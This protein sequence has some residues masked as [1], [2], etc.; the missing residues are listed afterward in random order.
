MKISQL[1][2]AN[3]TS[4]TK[5][6]VNKSSRIPHLSKVFFKKFGKM[7]LL[8]SFLPTKSHPNPINKMFA[9]RSRNTLSRGSFTL[10]ALASLFFLSACTCAG[11]ASGVGGNG[12]ET[13]A[14]SSLTLEISGANYAV[15]FD[16]KQSAE[17]SASMSTS[18]PP[19]AAVIRNLILTDGSTAK[20][21]SDNLIT[22]G[23]SVPMPLSGDKRKVE[24][25]VIGKDGSSRTYTIN[26]NFTNSE[27]NIDSL[28]LVIGGTDYPVVAFDADDNAKV[29]FGVSTDDTIPTELTI[30][31]L[32]LS[33]NASATDQSGNSIADGST[34]SIATSGND[35]SISIT[36][37][38]EDGS[39]RT[40]T[41]NIVIVSNDAVIAT[42]TLTINSND[43]QASFD[44]RDRATISV[45]IAIPTDT[46]PSSVTVRTISLSTGASATDG[47]SA[48]VTDGSTVNLVAGNGRQ[49]S[50][51]L[52]IKDANDLTRTYT[53]LV[54]FV[55][56]QANIDSLTLTV[57]GNDY[58]VSFDANGNA[59]I[60]VPASLDS[61]P[62]RATIRSIIVSA[63]ATANQNGN[64]IADGSTV[65]IIT[66]G[67]RHSISINVIAEDGST[68]IHV[69]TV[70]FLN[71][72]AN[73]DSLTLTVVG[74]DYPIVAFDASG[75]GSITFSASLDNPPSQATVRSI[76]VSANATANQNG[77]TIANGSTVS[78]SED[79]SNP[80]DASNRFISLFVTAE[81]GSTRTYTININITNSDSNISDLTLSVR[82]IDY[83]VTFD[84]FKATVN[85]LSQI[86]ANPRRATIQ[87]LTAS[88]GATVTDSSGNTLSNASSVPI[89]TDRL[90]RTITLTVTAEDRSTSTHTIFMKNIPAITLSGHS[91]D[92]YSVA[93]SPD[94]SKLA[95][96]SLDND[97]KIW[98]GTAAAN[99]STPIATLSGHSNGVRTVAYHPSGTKIASGSDDTT[100]KIWDATVTANTSTPIATISAH[101]ALIHSVAF[102]PNG[103]KIASASKDYIIKIWDASKLDDTTPTAPLIT[104]LGNLDEASSVVFYPTGSKLASASFEN[105][106][107]IWD[108]SRLDD[109]TNPTTRLSATLSG[110]TDNVYAINIS[111]NGS[112]LA[113]ASYDGDVKIW[114]ATVTANTST[115]FATLRRDPTEVLSVAF[116]PSSTRLASGGWDNTIKISDAN[117]TANTSRIIATL[118]D[119]T[120]SV[121]SLS[122]NVDGS[123]LASGSSDN[124]IKI[125][126]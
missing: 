85:G 91:D 100:I 72:Q 122:Y 34:V 89:V 92:V 9:I 117:A 99:T 84:Q 15:N 77:N 25:N 108:I 32:S 65:S 1:F 57:A 21:I 98:D 63:G 64:T 52:V 115:P 110:H 121:Q 111:P 33:A 45:P 2:Q 11:S 103:S 87:T 120:N 102:S 90:W 101:S 62:S 126:R 50:F 46:I 59:N 24:I 73:I 36:V 27:A 19:E 78:I 4:S 124:T 106:I 28:T 29:K 68:R 17:I 114:D 113:S 125:W 35:R 107:K 26:I 44:T 12:G 37:T 81:D 112:R 79:T 14:I 104:V 67:N 23:S 116:N 80:N 61:L 39:T 41:V 109:T 105:T 5:I 94:G 43:Y 97:I 10:L 18:A 123:R 56:N 20:D 13:N 53:I 69:I 47:T 82:G 40:Y 38:A 31:T 3:Q 70:R 86:N 66:S 22:D 118:S 75:N 42:L 55:N 51:T 8:F 83:P 49:S 93:F 88:R 74:N 96:G 76:I 48:T 6:G 60:T 16:G 30:K 119:H 54:Q 7:S 95:S 58:P 71:T